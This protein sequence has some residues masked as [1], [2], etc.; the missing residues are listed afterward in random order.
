MGKGD[1]SHELFERWLTERP[2][3]ALVDAWKDYVQAFA[4]TMSNAD[5]RAL[6][7]EVLQRAQGVAAAVGGFLGIGKKVS[8]PEQRVLE[9]LGRVFAD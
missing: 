2:P 1:V 3:Q 7:A 6:K 9:E 8:A 4:N 5:R